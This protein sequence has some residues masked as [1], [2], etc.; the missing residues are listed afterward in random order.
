MRLRPRSDAPHWQPSSVKELQTSR[1]HLCLGIL[2]AAKVGDQTRQRLY[3]CIIR[4]S[5]VL[6]L[7]DEIDLMQSTPDV[8]YKMLCSLFQVRLNPGDKP[9]HTTLPVSTNEDKLGAQH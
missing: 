4:E 2:R 9:H 7:R 3:K 6:S 8:H 1:F 5:H